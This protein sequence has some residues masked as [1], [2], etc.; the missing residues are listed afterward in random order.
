MAY[1]KCRDVSEAFW[2]ELSRLHPEEITRRT[3]ATHVNGRYRLPFFK[4]QLL[5][6]P[7]LR[8]IR[9]VGEEQT[10]PGFRVCLTTLHYL[11]YLDPA[12]LGGPISPLELAGGATFFRGHHGLPQGPL[13]NRFGRDLPA[14]LA[15]GERLHGEKRGAGDAAWAFPVF[16][17]LVVAV[18][19]WQG[20]EEFPP[21][22]TF[23]VPAHLDRFWH[24]DAVWG[25]LNLVAQEL[26]QAAPPAPD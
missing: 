25:L 21:Q 1:E 24:L 5:V 7:E 6:D 13:E 22:V 9:V 16:P 14:F 26:L 8:Q 4:G 23:T 18:I 17:G 2:L 11:L 19:L 20:D 10:D 15:A 3:G 12:A